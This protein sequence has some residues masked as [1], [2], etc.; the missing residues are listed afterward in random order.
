M[1]VFLCGRRISALWIL[2][3]FQ[4]LLV[5]PASARQV[6]DLGPAIAAYQQG[7]YE[8]ARYW[9]EPLASDGDHGAQ[10]YL[11]QVDELKDS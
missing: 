6:N 8:Q 7:D 4:L 5:S 9:F 3:I 11:A 10:F 1:R 2:F